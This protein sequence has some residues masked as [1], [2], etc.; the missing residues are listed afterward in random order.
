MNA[1]LASLGADEVSPW[2]CYAESGSSTG[3]MTPSRMEMAGVDDSCCGGGCC[4]LIHPLLV[5]LGSTLIISCF[6]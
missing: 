2:T 1:G 6:D 4:G 3:C 5:F